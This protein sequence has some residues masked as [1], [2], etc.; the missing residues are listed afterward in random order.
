M[1][2]RPLGSTGVS[3]SVIGFGGI[4]VTGETPAEAARLVARGINRGLNYFDVAP[5]YGNAEQMRGPALEPYRKD[6][7]L[8]CKTTERSKAGAGAAL[9]DSLTRLRTDH[10]DL[11]QMH[12]LASAE[13]VRQAFGPGGAIEAFVEARAAGLTRFLGFSAH[14]EQAALEAM[15]LFAFDTILFPLSRSSWFHGKFGPRVV[16]RA[17][18]K[19]MGILALKMLGKRPWREGERHVWSK[20][21]YAPVESY[22]EALEN[23]R[24]TLSL[25]VTAGPCPGPEQFLEWACDA[26]E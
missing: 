25:P 26:A 17:R 19:G 1:Q 15:E 22:A 24:F 8:A 18:A 13:D 16:E 23:V 7:F 10:F 21:W 6:V 9:R 3:L 11:Y 2:R 14:T 5:T 20:T 12:C 4:L